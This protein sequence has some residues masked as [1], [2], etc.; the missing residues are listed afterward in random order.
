MVAVAA[1]VPGVRDLNQLNNTDINRNDM[2]V[3]TS[4]A[5][6]LSA[7]LGRAYSGDEVQNAV[8]GAR[9]Q[10]FEGASN[11]IS[12]ARSQ[13]VVLLVRSGSQEQLCAALKAAISQGHPCLITMP[14]QWAYTP[15]NPLAPGYTHV[16]LAYAYDA[17]TL[18]VANVWGG[19][20]QRESW[21]WWSAR[22]CYGQVWEMMRLSGSTAPAAPGGSMSML[23]RT[24]DGGA[25]DASN[26]LTVN[27]T[28]ADYIW[29]NGWEGEHLTKGL[30]NY[31][32]ANWYASTENHVIYYNSAKNWASTQFSGIV[33]AQ[34]LD[35]RDHE[36][37]ALH[38]QVAT[39]ERELAALRE[40]LTA[41]GAAAP[42]STATSGAPTSQGAS[43]LAA[44]EEYIAS[45]K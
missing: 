38:Q 14:S 18:T 37:A 11:Y 29:A 43:L 25:R 22:L 24:A 6:G 45:L 28:V 34:Q 31:G 44:L 13:G 32:G 1:T 33:F 35:V 19:F 40:Q 20:N 8:Y 4:L 2:C 42:T 26:G 10:G 16:S 7:L 3:P 39:L 23:T 5:E 30:T 17:E 36:L 27:K 41:A 21:A 9:Y 15:R 12:Y